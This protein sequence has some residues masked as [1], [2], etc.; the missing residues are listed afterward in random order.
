MGLGSGW[1]LKVQT[2]VSKGT[3]LKAGNRSLSHQS[4]RAIEQYTYM[5]G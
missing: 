4:N 3:S 2:S 5:T 1:N